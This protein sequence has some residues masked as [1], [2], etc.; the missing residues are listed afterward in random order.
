MFELL[1]FIV[2]LYIGYQVGYSVLAWRIK[3]VLIKEAKSEGLDVSIFE[4]AKPINT[5]SQLFVERAN[6]VL[7]LYDK[8]ANSFICQAS[9]LEDLARLAKEYKNIKYAAVMDEQADIVVAFV[10]GRVE[11]N[12]LGKPHES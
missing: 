8:E 6:N 2:G 12:L 1:I 5:V 10:D 11:A 7:Y 3:D 9:T 4:D